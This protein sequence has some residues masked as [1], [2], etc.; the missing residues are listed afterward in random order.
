M[1]QKNQSETKTCVQNWYDSLDKKGEKVKEI[2]AELNFSNANA[3]IVGWLNGWTQSRKE[4][5]LKA[6]AKV[7]GIDADSLYKIKE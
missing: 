1:T 3:T 6:I 4:A 2:R 5:Q 7:S